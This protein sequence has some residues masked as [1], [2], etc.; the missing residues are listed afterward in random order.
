MT[1]GMVAANQSFF[2]GWCLCH[3]FN[4]AMGDMLKLPA[5]EPFIQ[6]MRSLTSHLKI[7]SQKYADLDSNKEVM[8]KLLSSLRC[9]VKPY[10]QQKGLIKAVG[11]RR[12]TYKVRNARADNAKR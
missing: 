5:F 7:P 10:L 4:L 3:P 2:T 1:Q 8:V 12:L 6:F 11:T 9:E